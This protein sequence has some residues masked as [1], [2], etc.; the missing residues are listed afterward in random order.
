MFVAGSLASFVFADGTLSVLAVRG[1]PERSAS[2]FPV[3]GV[4][5]SLL[6]GCRVPARG[7]YW[8][9]KLRWSRGRI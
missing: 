7:R 2:P 1:P 9:I 8:R 6:N 3:H 4:L 5:R